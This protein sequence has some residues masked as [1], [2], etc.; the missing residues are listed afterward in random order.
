MAA[1]NYKTKSTGFTK[2]NQDILINVNVHNPWQSLHV[3]TADYHKSMMKH[4]AI[5][6]II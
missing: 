4:D 6:F 2:H 3:E 5:H 1:V